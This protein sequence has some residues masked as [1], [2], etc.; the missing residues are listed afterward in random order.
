[1]FERHVNFFLLMEESQECMCFVHPCLKW[2]RD[3]LCLLESMDP[4]EIG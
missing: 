1:M 3:V 4:L 2:F